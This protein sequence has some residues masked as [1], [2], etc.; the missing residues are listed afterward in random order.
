MNVDHPSQTTPAL[1]R[2]IAELEDRL[3]EAVSYIRQRHN[4]GPRQREEARLRILK[5]HSKIK[6]VT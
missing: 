6:E 4:L 2:Y 3:E 5:R 1:L